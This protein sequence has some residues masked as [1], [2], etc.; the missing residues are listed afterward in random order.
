[1]FG[2]DSV[3]E[4]R[5]RQSRIVSARLDEPA[6]SLL[7]Q[8][9]GYGMGSVELAINDRVTM[10]VQLLRDRAPASLDGDVA[11][12]GPV[13]NTD[14]RYAARLDAWYVAGRVVVVGVD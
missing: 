4:R 13:R 6:Q 9:F 14:A 12:G 10:P 1:M 7:C 8:R 2:R 3:R 5:A 11:I